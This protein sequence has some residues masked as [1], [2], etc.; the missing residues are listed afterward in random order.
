M[1][2][3]LVTPPSSP[4]IDPV[5]GMSVD[6]QSAKGSHT[7]QGIIYHF[8]SASCLK[9]FQSDPDKYLKAEPPRL[10]DMSHGHEPAPPI[11]GARFI[12]PMDPEITSDRPGACPKC[13]MALEPML[14]AAD[15]E[16]DAEAADLSRRLWVGLALGVPLFALAMAEMLPE[17]ATR[18]YLSASASLV[19]QWLLATP[20]GVLVRLAV[21]AAGLGILPRRQR[22]HVHPDRAGGRRRLHL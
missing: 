11:P 9:K 14:P 20:R 7:H 19:E 17:K 21:R 13:G 18:S 12:C 2:L 6:P 3:G 22:Q 5:C 8:C 16:P 1:E 15:G 4:A 10:G